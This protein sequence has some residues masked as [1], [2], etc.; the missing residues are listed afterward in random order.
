M[1]EWISVKDRLPRDDGQYLVNG[2]CGIQIATMNNYAE[3]WDDA[4][5]DDYW[6]DLTGW[7]THWIPLPEAPH[8]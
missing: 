6:H 5:G 1:G 4:E 2:P 7:F 8:E 3:C